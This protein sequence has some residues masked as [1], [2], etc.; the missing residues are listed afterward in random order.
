M[1]IV[2]FVD[3][4]SN[5][6]YDVFVSG[7][8]GKKMSNDIKAAGMDLARKGLHGN[9]GDPLPANMSIDSVRWI[10]SNIKAFQYHVSI[11]RITLKC[12]RVGG[13]R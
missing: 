10:N 13:A 9:V 11:C 7:T 8:G 1:S 4:L 3:R 12:Q 5:L 2:I 6:P